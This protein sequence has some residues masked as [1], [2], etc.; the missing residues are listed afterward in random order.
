M[1]R[2][3]TLLIAAFFC[4]SLSAQSPILLKDIN[5]AKTGSSISQSSNFT[6]VN[7]ITFFTAD[8]GVHGIE[9]WKT[10]GTEAGTALVKDIY[11]GIQ[12]SYPRR[13]INVNGTLFFVAVDTY[14][15]N[16]ELWKSDGTTAGTV[17]VKDITPGYESSDPMYLTDVN[18]VLFFQAGTSSS[19]GIEL[20][21][22]DGTAAGTV[23]VKDIVPGSGSSGACNLVNVNGTLFF[24]AFSSNAPN[25]T[26]GLWKTDGTAAGT[27][28]VKD[29]NPAV[30]NPWTFEP[31]VNM[32]GTLFFQAKDNLHGRE[33]WKS[34]GTTAGTVMV[35]DINLSAE[36]TPAMLT[37]ADSILYFTAMDGAEGTERS[38]WKSD[39]TPEGT[40]PVTDAAGNRLSLYT[41]ANDNGIMYFNGSNHTD[42]GYELWKSDG[43]PGGTVMVKEITPGPGSSFM[44]KFTRVNGHLFFMTTIGTARLW[45]TD[46]TTEGTI[47][48]DPETFDDYSFVNNMYTDSNLLYFTY[49]D[50]NRGTEPWIS[51]GTNEGTKVLADVNN[52]TEGSSA[53]WFTQIDST[54]F[55]AADDGVHGKELWKTDGTAAGTQMVKDV[56]PAGSS[57]P[58]YLTNLNGMLFFIAQTSFDVFTL[59]KS[60]GTADGTVQVGNTD[61]AN[62]FTSPN[63]LVTVNGTLIFTA[64]DIVHGSEL[65][66]T[67]GTNA[68]TRMIKD[69]APEGSWI[70]ITKYAVVD[71]TLFF[72]SYNGGIGNIH[73]A[74][75]KTDGTAD[76]TAMVKNIRPVGGSNFLDNLTSFNGQL[77]F[78]AED[79]IHGQ[80]MWTSDGTDAGTTLFKEFVPGAVGSVP[81]S[82]R[83]IN[84]HLYFNANNN[85]NRDN[86]MYY[87]DGTVEGTVAVTNNADG[88]NFAINHDEFTAVNDST[89]F[90]I[91]STH[92]LGR[93]LW[94]TDGSDS[95]VNMVIDIY[96]GYSAQ[97]PSPQYLTAV[98][99]TLYFNASNNS[100]GEE[101]WKSD[102]TAAGT[103]PMDLAPG[104]LWSSSPQFLTAFNN[105][106][107][108]TAVHPVHGRELW[109]LKTTPSTWT[110]NTST[111]W[112]TPGNWSDN[113]VPTAGSVVIIPSGRP[114]YPVI[115]VN[116]TVY[117][118]HCAE[119]SAVMVGEGV[120]VRVRK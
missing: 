57:E 83:V 111:A 117:S 81:R 95:V 100:V 34:D 5:N 56:W 73:Y 27:V 43:T 2:I 70:E 23:M 9:L 55:F 16:M 71:S 28:L 54:V 72:T 8:D 89:I 38:L 46:G 18:G 61:S 59:F 19:G 88:S 7:G 45:K 105:R 103:V 108:F 29:I 109:I 106:L 58:M 35:K 1:K 17:M 104:A 86:G 93:E 13:L 74:L 101:L 15:H 20:W 75:W 65:W 12:A 113:E 66:Q 107:L 77:F 99:G 90:F 60:D 14:D 11:P 112:E 91:A 79:G 53:Y 25:S 116:T 49:L 51:D 26:F 64:Q 97:N 4:S 44:D 48:I 87:T 21:K 24:A 32:N 50:M 6:L 36:S 39:G 96:P 22:S 30:P 80:E 47:S 85:G 41:L 3:S 42:T 82:L 115:S 10:D 69:A 94:K 52:S 67:D 114:R 33:L 92:T 84:N 40:I 98:I 37:V 31:M 78:T 118:I 120:E 102:G 63:R 68:G 76:G 110:G 119:G 62:T